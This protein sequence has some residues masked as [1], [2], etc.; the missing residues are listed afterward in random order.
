MTYSTFVFVINYYD[1]CT[2]G[3]FFF[4]YSRCSPIKRRFCKKMLLLAFTA[5]E[6]NVLG[7]IVLR[8]QA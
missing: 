8:R 4:A 2:T 1:N 7:Q 6:G 3:E 5:K